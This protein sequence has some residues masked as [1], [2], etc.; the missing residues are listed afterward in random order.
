MNKKL[1]LLATALTLAV[2]LGLSAQQTTEVTRSDQVTIRVTIVDDTGTPLPGASVRIQ[3]SKN[4]AVSDAKGQVSLHAPRGSKVIFS[5]IGM[6]SLELMLDGPLTGP[7]KM[8]AQPSALDQVV[9]TGYSRTS[10]RRSA[11]S[12]A[13]IK[14]KDLLTQPLVGV[15][16]LLLSR[17]VLDRPLRS[18]SVGSIRSRGTPPLSGSSMGSPYNVTSPLSTPRSSSLKTSVI[19]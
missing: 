19:C 7:I 10:T 9:V 8:E 5:F 13:T 15:D 14:G 6:K 18:V 12:V 1:T 4:G 11:G 2:P 16:A 17:A 3:G